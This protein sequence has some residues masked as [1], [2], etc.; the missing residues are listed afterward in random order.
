MNCRLKVIH[1]GTG[2][3]VVIDLDHGEVVMEGVLVHCYAEF[4]VGYDGV[5]AMHEVK[6]G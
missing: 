1:K 6:V 3:N 2:L 5:V 4:V